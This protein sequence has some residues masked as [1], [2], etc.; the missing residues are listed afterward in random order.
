MS[1]SATQLCITVQAQGLPRPADSW[2]TSLIQSRNPA[3]PFPALVAT[4][5]SRLLAS[6][7]TTAG[8]LDANST[9]SFPANIAS[10]NVQQTRLSH[11]VYVQVLDIENLSKSRWEQVEELEAIE[12]GEQTRGREIIRLP[13][14]NDDNEVSDIG[15]TQATQALGATQIGGR[16]AAA[17]AAAAKN[18]T[19]RLVIQDCKGQ[20]VFGLE[21]G[22]I[23]RISIGSTNIGE[24]AL[25]K[26]GT[27]I[28]RGTLL[29]EPTNCQFFGGKVEVWQKD[30]L[31]KRLGRLKEAAAVS[32]PQAN[33]RR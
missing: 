9:I 4:A 22:R 29:L 23:D 13:T 31:E 15:S 11:N 19:H 28:A 12:R 7:W 25:I 2:A 21:L 14:G 10:A 16:Q 17:N 24:K 26:A 27:S 6:D 20:K 33:A 5:K 3:P 8:L 1:V 30:W 32:D 18:W